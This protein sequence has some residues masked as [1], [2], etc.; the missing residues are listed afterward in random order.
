[1]F[2]KIFKARVWVIVAWFLIPA[3]QIK[4][5][6]NSDRQKRYHFSAAES[7]HSPSTCFY[8]NF[9]VSLSLMSLFHSCSCPLLS[10]LSC[11]WSFLLTKYRADCSIDAV[12]G[13]ASFPEYY[14]YPGMIRMRKQ[15]DNAFSNI[16]KLFDLSFLLPRFEEMLVIRLESFDRHSK[17]STHKRRKW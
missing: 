16:F 13:S 3:K 5:F 4:S 17:P 14:F 7:W 15:R 12:F 10:H 8:F 6:L 2:L 11:I 1:M 9:F